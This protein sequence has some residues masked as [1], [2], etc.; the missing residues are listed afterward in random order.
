MKFCSNCKKKKDDSEFYFCISNKQ[1]NKLS[2]RCRKCVKKHTKLHYRA[3]KQ[4]YIDKIS[5]N[6]RK[7]KILI[8]SIKSKYG[9]SICQ[10]K[11][12]CCLEFHHIDNDKEYEIS[13]M[14]GK[15]RNKILIFKEINK[16]GVVCSNCH[17]KIH[18][19]IINND[20]VIRCNENI[21]D[22]FVKRQDRLY[23]IKKE[24]K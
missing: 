10:E 11:E 22:Y 19:G 9:C 15:G 23:Y 21:W 4:R 24:I 16:C 3:N 2:S 13:Q 20:K 18:S 14:V 5:D 12:G 8:Q 7:L 1:T 6:H 17:K